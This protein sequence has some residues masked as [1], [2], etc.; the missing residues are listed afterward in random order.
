MESKLSTILETYYDCERCGRRIPSTA[1][2]NCN[3]KKYSEAELQQEIAKARIEAVMYVDS[4]LRFE[5]IPLH[6]VQANSLKEYIKQ[7]ESQTLKEH[8]EQ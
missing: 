2:C 7:L 4:M 8:K 5:N 3:D 6:I 1:V